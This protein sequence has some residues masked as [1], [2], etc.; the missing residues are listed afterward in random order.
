MQLFSPGGG[1]TFRDVLVVCGIIVGGLV[2]LSFLLPLLVALIVWVFSLG[3]S[4]ANWIF[5]GLGVC[6]EQV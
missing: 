3:T 5:C 2:V 4:L 1:F 6:L